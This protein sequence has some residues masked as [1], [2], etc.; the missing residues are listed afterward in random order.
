[1]LDIFAHLLQ[2]NYKHSP[3]CTHTHIIASYIPT[4]RKGG[5]M[6]FIIPI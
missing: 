3:T 2:K 5:K 1:M 6:K 4:I